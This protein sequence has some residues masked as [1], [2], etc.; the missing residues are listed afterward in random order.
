M[1]SQIA[2]VSMYFAQKTV[3][4]FERDRYHSKTATDSIDHFSKYLD[5][6][7]RIIGYDASK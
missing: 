2:A 6:T 3:L 7:I 5:E 4:K 1:P